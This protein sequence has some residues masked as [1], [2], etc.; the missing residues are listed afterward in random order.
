LLFNNSTV[1]ALSENNQ[2]QNT[3]LQKIMQKYGSHYNISL[4]RQKLTDQ[5]ME[6]VVK[7]AIIKKTM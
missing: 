2:Y 5:D 1:F 7:E 3:E 6:F 4:D